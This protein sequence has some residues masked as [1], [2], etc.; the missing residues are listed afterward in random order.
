MAKP[1]RIGEHRQLEH[2]LPFNGWR[3]AS[4][5]R[6]YGSDPGRFPKALDDSRHLVLFRRPQLL[7]QTDRPVQDEQQPASKDPIQ[8]CSAPLSNIDAA[9]IKDRL[10]VSAS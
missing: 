10:Q 9:I 4:I 2:D 7:P 1:W 6:K 3:D 5:N 8:R